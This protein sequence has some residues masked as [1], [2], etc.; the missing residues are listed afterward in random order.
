M[1]IAIDVVCSMEVDPA[2]ATAKSEYNGKP[3]NFFQPDPR[4]SDEEPQYYEIHGGIHA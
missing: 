4:N 1:V 3:F 2:W